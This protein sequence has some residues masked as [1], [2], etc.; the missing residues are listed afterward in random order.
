MLDPEA[1]TAAAAAPTPGAP[2]VLQI[3]F[4]GS[5]SEYFRIWAV[6]PLLILVT[7]G[8]YLPFAKGRR[9]RH[10]HANTL[11]DGQ[12]NRGRDFDASGPRRAHQ[13]FQQALKPRIAGF[14]RPAGPP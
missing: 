2:R 1:T 8:L 6:N 4:T 11:V 12:A 9:I 10:F 3:R 5:G 7:L 13:V 14:P